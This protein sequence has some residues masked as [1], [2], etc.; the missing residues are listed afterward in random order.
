[1]PST[2]SEVSSNRSSLSFWV[3]AAAIAFAVLFYFVVIAPDREDSAGEGRRHAA[4]KKQL[5]EIQLVPLE[6]SETPVT[7]ASL[8]GKVVVLNF[9]AVWCPPCKVELPLLADYA[10]S[11][12]DNKELVI[13]PVVYDEP[14]TDTREWLAAA[15]PNIYKQLGVSIPTYFD[16]Q[17]VTHQAM[18]DT[19]KD[20]V[21]PTTVVLDRSGTIRGVYLGYSPRD[22]LSMKRLVD[23]LLAE[24]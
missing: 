2:N 9:W 3:V 23:D 24:K 16:P 15:V 17:A 8:T 12:R 11:Q 13:L 5:S 10:Y 20:S 6:G 14:E 21:F 18:V 19:V 1:M 7:A 22:F 4:V